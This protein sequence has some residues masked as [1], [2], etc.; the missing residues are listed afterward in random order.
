MKDVNRRALLGLIRMVIVM[1][2]LVFFPAWTLHYWQ[3][4]VCLLAFFASVTAITVYLMK[5]NP[6]L[7]ARRMKA[8][9][10]AEK[11]K[12][13]K[14]IQTFGA[15]AFVAIFVVPALDHRYVWST[16]PIYAE[17][18]GDVLIVLGFAFVF[19]VFKVNTFTSGVIEVA[20][21]QTVITSGPYT[22]VRHPMY[23]GALVMLLGIPLGLGSLW[24][25]L[26]FVGIAAVIAWR[27]L[28]EERFLVENLA[29][30][31]AYKEKVKHRLAPLV[32]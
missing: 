24:G 21:D 8:G 17:I 9:A 13:Q 25:L 15:I 3:A 7:L 1:P 12:S 16:V 30:Y 28:E 5:R 32:W 6:E 2:A 23:F 19:W 31:A 22:L 11:E 20:A 27:S 29:G 18:A 14:I 4:W 26:S 10:T